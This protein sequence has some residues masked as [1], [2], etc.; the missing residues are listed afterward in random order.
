MSKLS[1]KIELFQ[2]MCISHATGGSV[3]D[4]DYKAV[5]EELMSEAQI[6]ESLP[7]FIVTCRDPNQFWAFI[8]KEFGTYQ[9]RREYIW[10]EFADALSIAEQGV[11]P[12]ALGVSEVLQEYSAEGVFYIGSAR[13]TE[14]IQIQTEQ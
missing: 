8:K 2:N 12:V 9:E 1:E 13:S 11:A 14:R 4:A 6:R 3:I 5:R 7:R 10:K